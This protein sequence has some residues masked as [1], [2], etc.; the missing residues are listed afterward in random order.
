[1]MPEASLLLCGSG[2]YDGTDIQEAVLAILFLAEKGIHAGGT[3]HKT[4]DL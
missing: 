3:W 4:Y 2:L 1:M